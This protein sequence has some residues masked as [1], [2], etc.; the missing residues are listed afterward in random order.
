MPRAKEPAATFTRCQMYGGFASLPVM[1]ASMPF[2]LAGFWRPKGLPAERF[3]PLLLE[4]RLGDG[5]LA[6]CSGNG[7]ARLADTERP[8]PSRKARRRARRKGVERHV[9]TA[10]R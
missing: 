7:A 9:S 8:K 10:R 4:H 3:L 1:A 2:W 5:K 6:Y